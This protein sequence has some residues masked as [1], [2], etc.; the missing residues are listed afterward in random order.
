MFRGMSGLSDKELNEI[1]NYLEFYLA[2]K[3][4]NAIQKKSPGRKR[5]DESNTV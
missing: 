3:Q 1:S 4:L 5:K 2:K